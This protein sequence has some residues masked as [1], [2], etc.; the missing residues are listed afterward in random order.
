M[1]FYCSK[2][3]KK[4]KNFEDGV[5]VPCPKGG[6]H[7]L[8][9]KRVLFAEEKLARDWGFGPNDYAKTMGLD[10]DPDWFESFDSNDIGEDD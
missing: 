8:Y 10:Q 9:E 4:F 7:D 3:R 2:C 6:D 1:A 5:C